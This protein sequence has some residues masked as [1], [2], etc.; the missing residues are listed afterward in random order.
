MSVITEPSPSLEASYS[1]R[2]KVY[3][4]PAVVLAGGTAKPRVEAVIGVRVRA[5][6]VVNGKTLLSHVVDALSGVSGVGE[7]TVVGNVP[8]SGAYVQVNDGGDFVTN[9]FAGLERCKGAAYALVST[10]DLPY[11]TANSID[12]FLCGAIDLAESSGANIIYPIVGVETCYTQFPGVKRTARKL[13]EGKFTGGNM[14]LLRPAFMM[15][16]RDKIA[17]AHEARKSPARLAAMLGIGTLIRLVLS[18]S[19]SP[20]LLSVSMLEEKA[21]SLLGG[22]VRALICPHADIATDLDKPEDFIA[23]G[24]DQHT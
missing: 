9:I 11:V 16:H 7:I 10:S 22:S 8:E 6:A 20:R 23:A 14:V 5:M 15:K 21:S 24:I 13:K 19:I 2:T 17:K 12:A 18:Q 4:T 3:S 1:L